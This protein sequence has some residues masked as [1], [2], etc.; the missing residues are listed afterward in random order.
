MVAILVERFDG[1]E[2]LTIHGKH[3]VAMQL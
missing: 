3:P 1:V 2:S